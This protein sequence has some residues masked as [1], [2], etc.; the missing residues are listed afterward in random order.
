M[1]GVGSYEKIIRAVRL[2]QGGSGGW[3]EQGH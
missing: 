2:R 1:I 3:S